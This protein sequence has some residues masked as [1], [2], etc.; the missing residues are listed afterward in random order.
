MVWSAL[1]V[2]LCIIG[3]VITAFL[4]LLGV[5]MAIPDGDFDPETNRNGL[6]VGIP[7]IIAALWVHVLLWMVI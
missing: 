1:F 2:A 4:I 5:L 6:I 3:M 7:L